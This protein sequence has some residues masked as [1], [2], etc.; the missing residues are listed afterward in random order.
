[1]TRKLS[2][3]IL[4]LEVEDLQ[5]MILMVMI[6]I[7][8]ATLL[9][10]VGVILVQ[11]KTIMEAHKRDLPSTRSVPRRHCLVARSGRQLIARNA[12]CKIVDLTCMPFQPRILFYS[13]NTQIHQT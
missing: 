9:Q 7:D 8:L 4:L 11:H 5:V 6:N 12:P 3:G 2:E 1:L 13:Y 10:Q